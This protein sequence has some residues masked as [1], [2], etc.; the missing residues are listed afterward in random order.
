MTNSTDIQLPSISNYGDVVRFAHETANGF[1]LHQK[2]AGGR[3]QTRHPEVF[4]HVHADG[5]LRKIEI[6]KPGGS[7]FFLN[8]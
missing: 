5:K 4:I 7:R 6:R 8:P 2:F 3:F 1:H